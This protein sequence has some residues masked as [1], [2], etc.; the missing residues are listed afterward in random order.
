[1]HR[2]HKLI[3]L[4]VY[5]LSLAGSLVNPTEDF[6][7]APTRVGLYTRCRGGPKRAKINWIRSWRRLSA[8]KPNAMS[9]M[10]SIEQNLELLK[11]AD[12]RERRGAARELQH[13][14]DDRTIAPLTVALHDSDAEVRS[15]AALGLG[16]CE[17]TKVFEPLTSA[18]K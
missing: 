1:V 13:S 18:A 7:S 3:I 2:L 9:E 6:C 15:L 8:F 4:V 17:N 16:R 11:S 12:V 14:W 5:R 10:R